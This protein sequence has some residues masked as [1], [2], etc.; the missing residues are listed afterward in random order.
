MGEATV[1]GTASCEVGFLYLAGKKSLG[2]VIRMSSV[3]D[4]N[5]Y[6]LRITYFCLSL[7]EDISVVS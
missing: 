1:S 7:Q 6:P 4:R 3:N 2:L 5:H